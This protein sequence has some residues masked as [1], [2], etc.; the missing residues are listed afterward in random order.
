MFGAEKAQPFLC[1]VSVSY[2]PVKI[3]DYQALDLFFEGSL[4]IFDTPGVCGLSYSS[5]TS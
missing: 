5:S 1:R 2:L 4:Y 3:G